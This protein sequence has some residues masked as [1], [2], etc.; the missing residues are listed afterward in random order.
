MLELDYA[1]GVFDDHYQMALPYL[2]ERDFVVA[3]MGPGDSLGMALIAKG[4]GAQGSYLMDVHSAADMNVATYHR[5]GDEIKAHV[6]FPERINN[7]YSSITAMLAFANAEYHT[8]GLA[9]WAKISDTSVDWIFSHAVLEHVRLDEF[10]DTLAECARVLKPGGVTT[11]CVDMADHLG[12]SLHSLRFSPKVWESKLFQESGFYTNRLRS[13][14]LIAAFEHAGF[15]IMATRSREWPT[16]PL[17]REHLHP[18][19]TEFPDEVLRSH[20]IYITARKR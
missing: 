19:Y 16:V 2:P 1:R 18:D 3:E 20:T 11:H 13:T 7:D 4:Y 6:P 10:D 12:H 14:E 15:E 17:A 8:G 5:L 9:D